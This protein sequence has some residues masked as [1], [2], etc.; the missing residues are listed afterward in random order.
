MPPFRGFSLL[1]SGIVFRTQPW[2]NYISIHPR[3]SISLCTFAFLR[4]KKHHGGR[5]SSWHNLKADIKTTVYSA[6]V[7]NSSIINSML[8]SASHVLLRVFKLLCEGWPNQMT[9]NWNHDTFTLLEQNCYCDV[10]YL[11]ASKTGRV[12][13]LHLCR[14]CGLAV[15]T[16][17]WNS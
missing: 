5:F 6:S 11:V 13:F 10:F 12:T 8:F 4:T 16:G 7:F 14:K 9:T 3:I 2:P 17:D 1:L 15:H